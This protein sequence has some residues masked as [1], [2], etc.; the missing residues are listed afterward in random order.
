MSKTIAIAI[1]AGL[2][3]AGPVY[4][5]SGQARTTEI[6]RIFREIRADAPGC[7]VGVSQ[8]GRVIVNRQYGLA[9]VETRAP[10]GPG[11][12]FDIGSTHKQ[13][14]AAA[15]L[16]LVEARQLRLDDD[17]RRFLP[18]L[19][20]YGHIVTIDHLLTHTGGIRDWTGLLPFAPESTEALTIILRQRGL[21]FVPGSEWSYSNSGYVLLKEIVARVSGMSFAEFARRRIFEPLGMRSSAYVED[22]LHAGPDAAIGYQKES[23]GWRPFMRLGPNRGG[24]G[25]AASVG[26]LIT[27]QEA[28]ANGR[29]G[30]FV[31]GKLEENARLSNGRRLR[32]ARGLFVDSTPGGVVISHSGGAAGFSTWMGRVPEHG[33]SVAVA[34][35]FDPV[36]ASDLAE[37]VI[38]RF[39]PQVPEAARAASAAASRD[40][41]SSDPSALA[42]L[43]FEEG[44][45]EPLR[46]DVQ[47]GRLGFAGGP[48][49]V[50][51]GEARFRPP[52]PLIMYRSEDRFELTFPSPDVAEF[53]SME[54]QTARYRR[55]QPHT[56]SAAEMLSFAGRYRSEELGSVFEVTP[57]ADRLMVRI[58][59]R[60]NPA[61]PLMAVE[62]D[63]WMVRGVIMRFQRDAAGRVTGFD[64]GN[65]V[66][67]HIP[68]SRL[69]DPTAAPA[70][71]PAAAPA[72]PR[73]PEA[74]PRR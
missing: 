14:V 20:D 36:S 57:A 72:K 64:Y 40:S 62:R 22:I 5:Q 46:L 4:P 18:E 41:V 27:W 73:R 52:R 31:T 60:S 50:Q 70:A 17:I 32:Y 24:G 44:T 29:L 35:N 38:D 30:R 39:V 15:V 28:L 59:T 7:A 1:T 26:D 25:V 6:D 54:G 66:V 45:G 67:R 13:I 55:A 8:R 21:N 2:L 48:R 42:G 74:T 19:P 3:S 16:Q 53:R 49:L 34:C 9:N 61:V 37:A 10:L 68:F 12:L 47:R 33:L 56:H 51:V 11:S 65:P 71:P 23:N 63:T 69:G 58:E 43:F